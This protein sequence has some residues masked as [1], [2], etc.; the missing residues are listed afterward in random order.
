MENQT[1]LK[2]EDKIEIMSFDIYDP[3]SDS[4]IKKSL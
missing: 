4:I 1:T 3:I 2:L